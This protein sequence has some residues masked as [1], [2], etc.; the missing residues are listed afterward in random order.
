MTVVKA[1]AMAC[2]SASSVRALVARNACL[3][4]NQALLNRIEVGRIERKVASFRPGRFAKLRI[5]G[6]PI[7]DSHLMAIAVPGDVDRRRSEATWGSSNHRQVIGIR[8][9]NCF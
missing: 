1:S 6:E 7:S 5:L 3:T 9:C 2:S 8:Q 4:F